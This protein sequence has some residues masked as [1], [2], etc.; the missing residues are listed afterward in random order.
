MEIIEVPKIKEI[1]SKNSVKIPEILPHSHTSFIAKTGSG[2]SNLIVNMLARDKFKYNKYFKT[3]YIICPTLEF[4]ENYKMLQNMKH[5]K[6]NADIIF[7][8]EIDDINEIIL[9]I[10][11]ECKQDKENKLIILDDVLHLINNNQ[12]SLQELY[13]SGRHYNITIWASIQSYKKIPRTCR[14]NTVNFIIFK[15]N[16]DEINKIRVEIGDEIFDS[17]YKQITKK[18]E[19]IQVKTRENDDKRYTLNFQ[20]YI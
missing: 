14:L 18:Y 9:E 8:S 19:F 10:L 20:K 3:I 13:S 2:K 15:V 5:K 7:I 1:L 4:D 12:R 16:A 11:L 6:K 17:A